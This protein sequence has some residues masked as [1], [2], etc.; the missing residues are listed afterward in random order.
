MNPMV[1]GLEGGKMS[2]SDPDSKI[3]LLDD[4]K[5]VERKIRK[6]ICAPRDVGVENGVLSFVKF[7][8]LPISELKSGGHAK[9]C[10]NR[11]EK[12]GGP[13]TYTSYTDIER[14]FANDI[15][16]FVSSFLE[17]NCLL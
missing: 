5:T 16:P 7:V 17:A 10:I 11:D 3:D 1:R 4:A 2:A 9:F 13:I 8:L 14:D 6:S 15:V 12:W